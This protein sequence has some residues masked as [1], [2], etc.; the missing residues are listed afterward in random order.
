MEADFTVPIPDEED[1]RDAGTQLFPSV[2]D[3]IHVPLL[4]AVLANGKGEEIAVSSGPIQVFVRQ[5]CGLRYLQSFE[6]RKRNFQNN[7]CENWSLESLS[8]PT[9]APNRSWEIT[10]ISAHGSGW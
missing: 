10:P 4:L 7:A 5:P 1:S 6:A 3:Q 2:W 8:L 9:L